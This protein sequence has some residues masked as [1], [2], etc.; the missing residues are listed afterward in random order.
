MQNFIM[1]NSLYIITALAGIVLVYLVFNWSKMPPLTHFTGA[2]AIAIAAHVWEEDR[3][4]GG[5]TEM[6]TKK[7]NF[8]QSDPAFGSFV[9]MIYILFIVYVPLLFPHIAW[10]SVATLY[11]GIVEAIAHTAATKMYDKKP[12]YSPGMYT[13]LLLL[14]PIS[15]C[16]LWYVASHHLVA[17]WGWLLALVYT[18]SGLLIAQ[19]LVVMKSGMPYSEFL[20]NVRKAFMSKD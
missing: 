7:I 12:F 17:W 14:L 3:F 2:F 10:L 1:K 15:V 9:T 11:L 4:P 16:G 19:R 13:A 8:T 20:A 18:V 6:V 5:F